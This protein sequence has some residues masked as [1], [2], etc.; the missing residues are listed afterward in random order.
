MQPLLFDMPPPPVP[1]SIDLRCCDVG[2]LLPTVRGAALV[3]FD[4]PWVYN[5]S[6]ARGVAANH[7][8]LLCH[9]DIEAH[10]TASFDCAAVDA[11]MVVW[12]TWP[13]LAEWMAS[14]V[15]GW[16]Y[17]TGYAWGKVGRM[18]I[19]FHVRGDSEF[20]LIYVKGKPR[21]LKAISN[22]HCSERTEHSEKPIGALRQFCDAFCPPGALVFE[23][24][25]GLGSMARACHD[26]GRSYVGAEIDPE[27]HAAAL[28]RLA[29]H[30]AR[31]R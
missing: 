20:A 4:P 17:V 13:K 16:R 12:C 26:T 24:Y 19:G 2:E 11:Y 23:P 30:V 15:G 22:L 14:D 7:Y 18:G 28:G 25:A 3:H 27:R 9:A 8:D 10:V 6:G 21:P 1:A 5:N 29:H 31:S